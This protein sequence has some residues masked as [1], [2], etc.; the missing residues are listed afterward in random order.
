MEEIIGTTKV[1]SNKLNVC[2]KRNKKN[3][4]IPS[5]LFLDEG[6]YL[7]TNYTETEL[8]EAIEANPNSD[9][10]VH[11]EHQ[12]MQPFKHFRRKLDKLTRQEFPDALNFFFFM[13]LTVRVP[14]VNSRKAN[15]YFCMYR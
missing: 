3:W 4:A 13:L 11:L 10:V 2:L 5:Y 14:P 6:F 15:L 1:F 9:H 12:G 8:N 7:P